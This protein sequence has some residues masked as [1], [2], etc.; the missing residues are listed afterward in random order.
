[1]QAI[2]AGLQYGDR[3]KRGSEN[4]DWSARVPAARTKRDTIKAEL[5]SL[6]LKYGLREPLD[7][8]HTETFDP[9]LAR[10]VRMRIA[11]TEFGDAASLYEFEVWSSGGNEQDRANIALASNGSRLAAGPQVYAASFKAEPETTYMLRRG[12]PMQRSGEAVHAIPAVLGRLEIPDEAAETERRSALAQPDHPLTARV[13]VNRVWQHH[14][15]AGLVET[16]TDFGYMGAAPSH[17]EL[18]DWLAG[19]FVAD[20]GGGDDPSWRHP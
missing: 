14:F 3:R 20:S 10:S 12:D 17:P 7:I 19:K 9:V 4:D 16:S 15:G 18:L 8:V 5:E 13:I 11:K 1:M 2:F 6:R